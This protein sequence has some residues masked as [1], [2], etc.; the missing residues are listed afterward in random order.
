MGQTSQ[1]RSG[2][3][4]V[5]PQVG[6]KA[7]RRA[8]FETLDPRTLMCAV[9]H[10]PQVVGATV[11]WASAAITAADTTT[12][13]T[14]QLADGA[15]AGGH[16]APL[17]APQALAAPAPIR[18]N[19]GG[20][21]YTDPAGVY[22][23]G[24]AYYSGT[25]GTVTTPYAVANTTSDPLYYQRRYGSFNYNIPV[26][27]AGTYTLR[28]HFADA[29]YTTAGNRN[30]SVRAENNT[31][32]S[33]FDVAASGGGRAA[34]VRSF[35]V[36]V[37]DGTL[38]LNF[39]KGTRENPIV[40]AVEVIPQNTSTTPQPPP[41]PPAPPTAPAAGGVTGLTLIN[42]ATN[43][44]I[45]TFTSGAVLDTSG[46]R[47]YSV[48]ADVSSTVGSVKFLLDGQQVR[49]ESAAPLSVSGDANG[50]YPAWNVPAGGHTLTVVP[51]SGTGATGT[52]GPAY[53]VNFTVRSTNPTPV[54]PPP[55]NP[56]PV[57]PPPPSSGGAFTNIGYAN[58]AGNPII[59][60]E[61]LSATWNGRLYTFGGF[62][63]NLG[64]VTRSDYFNPATNSW[65]R[66]A[67]LPQRI[68]H[69]GVAQ[70]G[71]N[72]YFVGGYIGHAGQTGY[73]Q[74]FGS[75]RVWRYNFA[76][77]SYSAVTNLPRALS[78][79]GAA[80]IG[81]NLHYFG[82]QEANRGDTTVHLVL[83]LDNPAAGWQARKSMTYGRSHL[84]G[85][86][87]NGKLY[88]IGGQTGNDAGLVTRRYV[89]VYDPATD[90]WTTRTQI[91]KPV[92]NISSATFVMNGR[93]LVM[94]GE[95]SHNVQVRDVF[96]YDPATNGWEALTPLPAARFS[97]AA[98]VVNGRIYF[99]TGGS[100]AT[101]W[102]GRPA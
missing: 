7:L 27:A 5:C 71:Q 45:G 21:A 22:W 28:L 87:L 72:V 32:L 58:K 62:S 99:S 12:S 36:A 60:A 44:P 94:G 46:G 73:G 20:P 38:N 100:Q 88:A 56:T 41:P 35:T 24:D 43:A 19:A 8:V 47:T 3:K 89:E 25:T 2:T 57:P 39:V 18:I 17:A 13:E 77:N 69:A 96:A 49:I 34:I 95:S 51:Y 68:T 30:F 102:E 37:N 55:P 81:R 78:G 66:V 54:P 33:N 65:T 70:D 63:G 11:A 79:G 29:V 93:L 26:A 101:T 82:G 80:I 74:T 86:A 52:A 15:S 10:G 1:T 84:G 42:A 97:G 61:A 16:Q 9:P 76:S 85:V 40:S 67:D 83:N 64:P 50:D 31:V 91:P 14:G 92:S 90:R 75:N 59:R 6:R 23:R 98:G 53:S 48:R 4:S